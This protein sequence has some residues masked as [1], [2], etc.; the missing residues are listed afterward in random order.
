MGAADA[1]LYTVP[2]ATPAL[3][4]QLA[5]ALGWQDFWASI[6]RCGPEKSERWR[7]RETADAH[8]RPVLSIISLLDNEPRG[9]DLLQGELISE[10]GDNVVVLHIDEEVLADDV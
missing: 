9:L 6:S 3:P 2:Y 5:G 4:S 1:V 7:V 8:G 10:E